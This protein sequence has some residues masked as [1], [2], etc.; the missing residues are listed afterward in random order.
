MPTDEGLCCECGD[1]GAVA[2]FKERDNFVM[3]CEKCLEVALDE[4]GAG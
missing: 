3:V 4:L 2:T 1:A